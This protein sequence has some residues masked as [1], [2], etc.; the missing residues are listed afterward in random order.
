MTGPPPPLGTKSS[1]CLGPQADTKTT[2]NEVLNAVC[3]VTNRLPAR[4]FVCCLL[5]D[6]YPAV[7]GSR[8]GCMH[9]RRACPGAPHNPQPFL[10]IFAPLYEGGGVR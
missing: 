6:P 9:L 1:F 8:P 7:N 3:A 5:T 4:G 10:V 2:T